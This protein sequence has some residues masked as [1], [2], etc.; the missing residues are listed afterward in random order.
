MVFIL[1]ICIF[2]QATAA[3]P[4]ITVKPK[5]EIVY[6]LWNGINI[7]RSTVQNGFP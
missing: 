2:R 3:G 1:Q 6:R 7:V 4:R 5:S